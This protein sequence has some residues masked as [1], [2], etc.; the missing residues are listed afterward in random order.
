MPW[1]PICKNEYQDGILQC[2]ECKVDLVDELPVEDERASLAFISDEPLAEKLVE[3]LGYNSIDADYTY[4]EQEES[5]CV[6]V[7]QKMLEQAR[8]AFRAF[9]KVESANI[10]NEEMQKKLSELIHRN[11]SSDEDDDSEFYNDGEDIS[12]ELESISLE[13]LS[14]SEKE[15][16]SQALVSERVYKPAEVYVTKSDE[17]KDMFSTAITFLVFAALLVVFLILNALNIITLF[18]NT[19]SLI[20]IGAMSLACCLVGINAIKRSRK[21]ELESYDEEK[22]TS[23]IKEWLAANITDDLFTELD[24]SDLSEEVLY[25]KRTEII[26]QKLNET[27]PNLNDD[28]VDTLLDDFYDTR[29]SEFPAPADENVSEDEDT[30]A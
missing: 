4:D 17:S 11:S 2:A 15:L 8:S 21:A 24:T 23:S 12:E 6:K 9:Y 7:D 18:N 22:L 25:L 16:L 1:C 14:D 5:F 3:Y 26:R 13:N 20:V 29:F 27:Y 19:A 28:Y 10:A 30:E